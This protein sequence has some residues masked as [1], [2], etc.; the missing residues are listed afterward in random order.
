MKLGLPSWAQVLALRH[1]RGR[2]SRPAVKWINYFAWVGVTLGVFA[3]VSIM[4]LMSGLQNETREKILKQKPHLLWEHVPTQDLNERVVELQKFK[5]LQGQDFK[6]NSVLQTEGIVELPDRGETGRVVG[7]GVIIQGVK[8]FEENEIQLGSEL[9]RY[10]APGPEENLRLRSAWRPE[11]LPLDFKDPKGF[12]SGIF[13]LD[14]SLI[15]ISQ[16]TLESWLG[17]QGAVSR[18]EIFLE[19]PYQAEKLKDEF[20]TRLGVKFKTWKQTDG[21]LWFSLRLEKVMMGLVLFFVVLIALLALNL[22]IRVRVIEKRAEIALLHALGASDKILSR[23]F[24]CQG[25]FLGAFASVLGLLLGWVFCLV[26]SNFWSLPS[27]YYSTH[28][29]VD[30]NWSL[31]LGFCL[32]AVVWSGIASALP[33]R[34]IQNLNTAETLRS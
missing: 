14:R 12:E 33:A 16:R 31:N 30:W 3:W 1:L 34:R 9:Q 5:T 6:I 32:I 28:L 10:L 19:D 25:V 13:E 18:I 17:L 26:V 29:P 27:I 20:E 15:R 8:E 22:S 23:M 24:V 2:Y 4:S 7:S 21:A 11:G